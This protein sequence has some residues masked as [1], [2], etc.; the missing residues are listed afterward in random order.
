MFSVQTDLVSGYAIIQVQFE[1]TVFYIISTFQEQNFA[2]NFNVATASL[3]H[4]KRAMCS[5]MKR[6]L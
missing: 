4:Q 6:I 5:T 3:G 1:D 2:T